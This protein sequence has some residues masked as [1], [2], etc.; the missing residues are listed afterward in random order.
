M[1]DE[2]NLTILTVSG[3]VVKQIDLLKMNPSELV[4]IK[5]NITGTVE[6]NLEIYLPMGFTCTE[7]V[8][9]LIIKILNIV[10]HHADNAV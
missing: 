6:M 8:Q 10:Q 2:L 9:K 7:L 4:I 1:P 3:K 5:H